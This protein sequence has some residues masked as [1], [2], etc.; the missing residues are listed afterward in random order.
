VMLWVGGFDVIYA[1]Q[2]EAFDRQAGL[3]SLPA[4]LGTGGALR[5]S[6]LM[7]LLTVGLLLAL[8]LWARLGGVYLAGVAVVAALLAYEHSLVRPDDLSKVN[9]AFFTV[10]GFVSIGLFLFTAADI[11][12][13]PR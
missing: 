11:F 5:V 7:H 4:R 10:N 13:R 3:Q 1:C 8:P 2:D 12:L 6:R 9:A